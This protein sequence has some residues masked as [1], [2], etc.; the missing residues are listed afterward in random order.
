MFITGNSVVDN[1][2]WDSFFSIEIDCQNID[3]VIIKKSYKY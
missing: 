3:D 1:F 2:N